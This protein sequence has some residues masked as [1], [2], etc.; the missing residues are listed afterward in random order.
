MPDA[1]AQGWEAGFRKLAAD[2]LRAQRA[3]R[4]ALNQQIAA[5]KAQRDALDSLI[6]PLE[7]ALT[8]VPDASGAEEPPTDRPVRE[9]PQ[10]YLEQSP[11]QPLGAVDAA[12]AVLRAAGE[13]LH[14]RVITKRALDA[15]LWQSNAIKPEN[16]IKGALNN[17]IRKAGAASKF[18]RVGPGVF[19]LQNA[20]T[21][22]SPADHTN[23]T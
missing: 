7:Q 1:D 2:T 3:Q 14:F 6:E 20:S 11:E 19:A 15:R 22:P 16:S 8:S 12:V 18:R 10:P 21:H 13:P 17:H 9:P 4:D 23:T 5:L